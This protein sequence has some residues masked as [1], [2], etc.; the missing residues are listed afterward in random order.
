MAA[1]VREPDRAG[2]V[3]G[4]FTECYAVDPQCVW[5]APGRVN[6]IGEHTDYNGGFVLP[7][8]LSQG[9]LAVAARRGGDVL[10]LR[11]LQAP[12]DAAS[13]RVSGLEPGSVTG[14]AAYPA[15]VAWALREAGHA[16]GGAAVA[17]DSDLAR[18]AGLASSAALECAVVLAL[19]ELYEVSLTRPE[20]AVVARRAENDFVGVPTGIMD[21]SASLLCQVG[22]ALLLDC[23]SG[24]ASAV[25]LAPAAAGLSLLVID[26]RVR[27]ELTSSEY[28]ARRRDCEAA[29][30]A[31][32]VA[33][34]REVTDSRDLAASLADPAGSLSGPAGSLADLAASLPDPVLRRRARHVITENE[35]V[36][37]IADLLRA[38]Q[39]A[40]AGPLLSQSHRSLRDDFEISWPQADV[41]VDAAVAAG[42]FGARM[43]GGGFGGCV[44]ALLPAQR[45]APVRAE[46]SAAYSA[47]GWQRPAFLD[48]VPAGGARRV[49]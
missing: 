47:R 10:E 11:S 43:T 15:G 20:A 30:R 35:R 46:V 6:L 39:L 34:L 26:T 31:L 36:E 19:A 13:V 9:T 49:G 38:G 40:A 21:Q 16:I 18:G 1:V 24:E 7:F 23:R 22:H 28:G 48:A 42:A 17:V 29:A 44:L 25:P 12:A 5:H 2:R 32:G 3:I 8:A 45:G 33:S 37:R 14:W 41:A 27:H 4:W